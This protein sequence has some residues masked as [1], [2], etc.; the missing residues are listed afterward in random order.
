MSWRTA[1]NK[2][3]QDKAFIIAKNLSYDGYLRR[4]AS[5]AYKC[6]L[7]LKKSSSGAIKGKTISNRRPSNLA[8]G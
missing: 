3:F 6:F 4:L 2:L 5:M 8:K 1:S 7:K